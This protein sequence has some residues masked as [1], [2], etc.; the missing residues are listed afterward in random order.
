MEDTFPSLRPY[1]PVCSCTL[2][3]ALSFFPSL[4]V[5]FIVVFQPT[6]SSF[7]YFFCIL[8]KEYWNIINIVCIIFLFLSWVGMFR[9]CS[10]I[11]IIQNWVRI[12]SPYS[13]GWQCVMWQ[14]SVVAVALAPKLSEN[15]LPCH[16]LRISF[17]PDWQRVSKLTY[18]EGPR[19]MA[20]G[21]TTETALLHVMNSVYTA[22]DN[23]KATVLV[24]L[25]ISAAF[26][27]IAHDLLCQ[28]YQ[29]DFCVG[30]AAIV[31]LHSY[32]ADRQQHVKLVSIH[33]PRCCASAACRRA[34]YLDRCSSRR[35]CHKS[36]ISSSHMV[37]RTTSSLTTCSCSSRW[38]RA[39]RRL[40]VSCTAV[41]LAQR[42]AA[43]RWQIGGRH[44]RH[45]A[46]TPSYR[47]HHGSRSRRQ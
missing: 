16:R 28:I 17:F 14:E 38:I 18:S 4:S 21:Q 47:Q 40:L 15:L 20:W 37:C 19:F 9:V 44:P 25:D 24:G 39:S 46:P 10:K 32:L 23:K 11:K 30:D 22:A 1:L 36:A 3:S 31:W 26:D 7:I 41:V 13:Q 27:A 43:E 42:P 33:P 35:T 12:I 5:L 2:P 29:T 6:I 8:R 34:R 45:R